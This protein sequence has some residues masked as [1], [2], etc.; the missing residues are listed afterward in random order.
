MRIP[1][2]SRNALTCCVA[3]AMLSG[4]GGSHSSI[5][6]TGVLPQGSTSATGA[7]QGRSGIASETVIYPF[8]GSSRGT[9]DGWYPEAGL[10]NVN[11][12]LFGT[13]IF[14]GTG[15]VGTIFSV[16]PSGEEHV[17]YSFKNGSDGTKPLDSL[18]ALNGMLYGTTS[19]GGGTMCSLGCGTV[20]SVDPSSGK[21]RILYRFTGVS[22]GS[23]APAGLVAVNG[24]LYGTTD[25]GGDPT[26]QCGTI[27][28]VNPVSGLERVLYRFKGGSDGE[29]PHAGL[30][31]LGNT[32]Y[33]TTY[34]GGTVKCPEGIA[35][36]GTVFA[37][38]ISSRRER[39]VH[40]FSDNV[41]DGGNP[42]A[43]LIYMKG[44]LYGTT[45]GGGIGG[46]PQPYG[47]SS[48]GTVFS[49]DPSSGHE[50][51]LHFFQRGPD[52]SNPFGPLVAVNGV[53]YGTTY[54]G[55]SHSQSCGEAGCGTV[56]R[57][58]PSGKERVLHDFQWSADGS[59]PAAGLISVNGALYGTTEAGG[60]YNAFGFGTVFK[61]SP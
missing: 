18:I 43:P 31:A 6:T 7:A 38:N 57:V 11:G 35:G 20:F 42:R 12:T 15:K 5:G 9:V 1:G 33:G 26:C 54:N 59:E 47:S 22:D 3:L 28:S 41:T 29:D 61:V 19:S 21:E 52:G 34:E 30:L 23:N 39:V 8:Q 51:I 45:A 4:C 10:I 46:C 36:C 37:F 14:G 60:V 27:F 50:H 40:R 16:S 49:L 58:T 2:F 53:L 55:G 17:V 56:F 25:G 24:T 32:L 44:L 13:T 48:C